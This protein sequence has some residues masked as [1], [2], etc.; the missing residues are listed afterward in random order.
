MSKGEAALIVYLGDKCPLCGFLFQ[1]PHD[2]QF[3]DARFCMT[4]HGRSICGT[5]WETA[6][7]DQRDELE[8]ENDWRKRRKVR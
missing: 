1:T 8:K 6:T 5:C 3:R 4:D 2:M 7:A